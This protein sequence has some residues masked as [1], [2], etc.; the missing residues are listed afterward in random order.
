VV[1]T[2][3]FAWA[4]LPKTAGDMVATVLGLFPEII[5]YADPIES[6]AKHAP[7]SDRPDLVA[8]RQRVLCIRRLP[9]WQLSYSVHKSRHG[10]Q[11][12]FVPMPMDSRETMVTSVVADRILSNHV[13]GGSAWP[14]RWIRVEHLFDDLLDLLE[15]HDVQ[16][17]EKKR[18]KIRA[19]KPENKGAAY[20]RSLSAWFTDEM[21]SRMYEHNPLWHQAE[22]LAYADAPR[23]APVEGRQQ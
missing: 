3:T 20:E 5:E 6:R 7:F 14:D 15:E 18:K 1:I 4:H 10:V 23:L 17:T 9:A 11:P 8:G 13:E 22:Q 19:M 16:V 12:H 21:V 2:K